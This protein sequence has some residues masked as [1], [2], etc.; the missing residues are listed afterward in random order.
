MF[1]AVLGEHE[2]GRTR[3]E[4]TEGTYIVHGK[5]SV[6]QTGTP[7]KV[8]YAKKGSPDDYQDT[9]PYLSFGDQQHRIA[10]GS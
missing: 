5:I 6:S 3:L 1:L 9:P 10:L 4:T 7:V 2:S 8:G